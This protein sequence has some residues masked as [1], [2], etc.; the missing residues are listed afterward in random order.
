MRHQPTRREYTDIRT[1]QCLALRVAVQPRPP[2]AAGD[3]RLEADRRAEALKHPRHLYRQTS[4]RK[5]DNTP[6]RPPIRPG[7]Q[8]VDDRQ[9]VR[10]RLA[11]PR[12]CR[13][14]NV[15]M[16]KQP[17]V[18]QLPHSLLDTEQGRKVVRHEV[19]PEPGIHATHGVD[20]VRRLVVDRDERVALHPRE[21]RLWPARRPLMLRIPIPIPFSSSSS[22]LRG[23]HRVRSRTR[24][25]LRTRSELARVSLELLPDTRRRDGTLPTRDTK[26]YTSSH[27]TSIH[28]A[29]TRQCRGNKPNEC[30]ESRS[31]SSSPC[32]PCSPCSPRRPARPPST[33]TSRSPPS[34]RPFPPPQQRPPTSPP[35]RPP[36]TTNLATSTQRRCRPSRR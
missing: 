19:P 14:T 12:R 1:S 23:D 2:A 6:D 20:R 30:P 33:P 31:S 34:I 4:R 35:P 24:F 11:T 8:R 16:G 36:L 32:S 15:V 9:R 18:R 29:C 3:H 27:S 22:F 7:S 17:A 26:S 5:N 13:E 10:E 28:N 21:H 25:A